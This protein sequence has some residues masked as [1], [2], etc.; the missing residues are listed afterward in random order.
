MDGDRCERALTRIAAA[1]E[2]IEAA[3]RK[4]RAGGDDGELAALRGRHDRLRTVIT[5]S[6][7]EIDQLIA[8]KS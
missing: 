1:A 6:L 8:G 5:Q 2:R 7:A 3:A 4:P